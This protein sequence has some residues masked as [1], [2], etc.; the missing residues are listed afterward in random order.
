MKENYKFHAS[1]INFII[2]MGQR[3]LKKTIARSVYT[4]NKSIA[5][6]IARARRMLS[7]R[8]VVA[9]KSSIVRTHGISLSRS[10]LR[11]RIRSYL[12]YAT[13]HTLRVRSAAKLALSQLCCAR[14]RTPVPCVNHRA[15]SG[16]VVAMICSRTNPLSRGSCHFERTK[17]LER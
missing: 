8:I 12:R 10:H 9:R 13:V 1:V 11:M 3:E 5:F 7:A 15:R 14:A 17:A 4:R 16:R 6:V 2:S